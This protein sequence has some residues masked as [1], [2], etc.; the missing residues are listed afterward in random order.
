MKVFDIENN[1]DWT[2][3]EIKH[4]HDD[5]VSFTTYDI[6][7]ADGLT[8]KTSNIQ[9]TCNDIA[10]DKFSNY[11]LTNSMFV[12][13]LISVNIPN[14]QYPEFFTTSLLVNSYP[15]ITTNSAYVYVVELEERNSSREYIIGNRQDDITVG[16]N[17]WPGRTEQTFT[18]AQDISDNHIYFNITL[19]DDKVCSIA[20]NDNIDYTFL[21]HNN[22][23][24]SPDFYIQFET[25][26]DNIPRDNQKFYYYINKKRGFIIL[27]I[28]YNG[29]TYWIRPEMDDSK[30]F[31]ATPSTG[32]DSNTLPLEMVL[33]YKPYVRN[34]LKSNIFNNWAS[35]TTTGDLNN[36]NKSEDK[37]FEDVTNNYILN[38]TFSNIDGN[39]L[40]VDL[41][42]L[43]NQITIFGNVNR[44][45]PFPNFRDVDHREYDTLFVT[46]LDNE[47]T[48]LNMNYNS[49]ETEVVAHP[50]TI[51]YFNT[52]QDMYP[53]DKININD[54]S[55]IK[56]G[57]IGGDTPINSDKIFKKAASYKYN[58]PYGA[59]TDEETGTWL[60]SWL[61]SNIGVDWNREVEFKKNVI[62]NYKGAVYRA[63]V[64]NVGYTPDINPDEWELTDQPPPV[65]VD[66]YY[67]PSKFSAQEALK[68]EGQYSEYKTKFN[69]I[70]DTLNAQD[71]YIFD[72]KSDLTFEP[73]SLYAYYRIGPEQIKIITENMVDGLIHEGVSDVR[74][75][76][77]NKITVLS[78][79]TPLLG[80]R[81]VRTNTPNDIKQSD[82]SICF[83]LK[84]E[85]WKK[86]IGGQILGNYTNQGVGV[87]NKQHL[88]PY[89][90]LKNDNGVSLYNTVGDQVW[91]FPLTGTN[92]FVK[93]A[94]NEDITLYNDTT[95]EAYDLKGMLVESTTPNAVSGTI[96]DVNIDNNFHYVLDSNNNV[97]RYDISTE[98]WDQLNRAYPYD[99]VIGSPEHQN[100]YDVKDANWSTS[101]RTFIQPVQNGSIQ[102]VV[103][104]DNYAVDMNDHLWF[105]KGNEVWKLALSN[106]Q[107]VNATFTGVVG[108][109][110]NE[111]GESEV[112]LIALESL[113]GSIGNNITLVGDDKTSLFKLIS[114]HNEN[115]PT[116]R[117]ELVRGNPSVI[118]K[119]GLENVIQLEG[120]VDRGA[121]TITMALSTQSSF[122]AI[123][124]SHDNEIYTLH[125]RH[126]I[127]KMN[128]LRRPLHR[129]DLTSILEAVPAQSC[130]DI[131]SEFTGEY[132]EYIL[133]LCR[134]SD[135]SEQVRVIKLSM[136]DLSILSDT[137]KNIPLDINLNDQHNLTNSET[138]KQV[139]KNTILT[140]NLTFQLRYQS[141]FDTDKTSIVSLTTNVENLAPGYHSFAFLFNSNNSNVTLF[142]D[143]ILTATETSD[144]SASGAAYKY[145]KTIH[146]PLYIGASP[147]F[148]NIT[149]SERLGLVNYE[150]VN[151]A[152][153]DK[154]RIYNKHLNFQKVKM[155]YRDGKK[156]EPI[157]LTLPTGKRNYIDH[158]SKFYKHQ[159]PGKKS[160]KINVN[161]L[162]EALS[163]TEIQNYMNEELS[164]S[165][166]KQMPINS[167][168]EKINWI[169]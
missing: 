72:K 75:F 61:K 139:Y 62:V 103:N 110:D 105:T 5:L 70:V 50:D 138:Y 38:S 80:D 19:H 147:F 69:H 159:I 74:D 152:S 65:W 137:E 71:N 79:D 33:R 37:S 39:K 67:N 49:Y 131:V 117:V 122:D 52:P 88:T 124:I 91:S 161:I 82:F 168:L 68:I 102:Y 3:L 23:P 153:I 115:E 97:S 60:C 25:T 163:G 53:F 145:T 165:I 167:E 24:S 104:C 64:D 43:K 54:S 121:S 89:I 10:S 156:I 59:P 100:E 148:N 109:F 130:M 27:Y 134:L 92:T 85:D 127:T 34:S 101:S 45:N 29:L 16:G 151:S 36:L 41:I 96:V 84:A 90:Y 22:D 40:N 118:P 112:V 87:F 166:L 77:N 31:V 123:K 98:L 158:A 1:S 21:T 146:D 95:N 26:P 94:G 4:E 58:T 2:P 17:T 106:K 157:T 154:V 46:D 55:L 66:R 128:Y 116:N 164:E 142:I 11:L 99:L 114:Q 6:K 14:Q 160:Q 143:G 136:D 125:D 56:S 51:T 8:L 169:S 140:N 111:F 42:Q 57:A 107:G 13:D 132:T 81:Y 76:N 120:G 47:A 93:L 15:T 30:L 86:P 20:H 133:L 113:Q 12:N 18:W 48:G 126:K 144:D 35:Y 32:T 63:I 108:S 78:V 44:N 83:N 135:A 119:S 129:I 73:G 9:N 150:F 28:K 162:N 141:Y 149:F 7:T 155:L